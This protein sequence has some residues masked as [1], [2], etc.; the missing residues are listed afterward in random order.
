VVFSAALPGARLRMVHLL[1]VATG[2]AGVALLVAGGAAA[3][4]R[5]DHAFGYA[6]AFAAALVWSGY[7]VSAR[8]LR[9]VSTAS[10]AG[11]C[12]AT[13]ALSSTCHIALEATVAPTGFEWLVVGAIGLGP[14]GAAF[15]LWDHGIKH[16][17][18]RTLGLLSYATPLMSTVLLIALGLAPAT[19]TVAAA[20]LLIVGG[21][22]V[23]TG[24]AGRRRARPG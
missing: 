10:V 11:F 24:L 16:G 13:A 14:L 21:A 8:L 2:F 3:G 9:A 17:D 7:S 5:A 19:W 1:G 18:I 20:A 15:F 12:L 4:P 23:G 6:A 22:M